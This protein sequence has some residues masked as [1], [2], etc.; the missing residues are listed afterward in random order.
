MAVI[1]PFRG[2][3]YNPE[4]VEDLSLV[5]A[6]PYDVISPDSQ[7]AFHA[8]HDQNVIRLI[9]GEI[10]EADNGEQN[11]YRRAGDDFRRWQ[12]EKILVRDP[13]PS[14]YLYQQVFRAPGG[15]ELT[16]R[17]LIALVRLEDFGGR[18]VFPHERTMAAPKE[19]RLRLMQS[20]HANLS[21][22][23]GIY[24][25]PLL[26]VDRLFITEEK[27]NPT[28]DLS[29]WDGIRHRVWVFHDRDLIAEVRNAFE[30]TPIFIA[31]GHHRYETAL[32][33]RDLMR[34]K[35]QG[36]HSAKN[37]RPYNYIMM[38]LVSA[39]DPGLVILPIH[40][41]LRDLP[42]G[43]LAAYLAQVS[44]QFGVERMAFPL[45][46]EAGAEAVLGR[47]QATGSGI[48]RFGLY[49]GGEGAYVLTLAD[50][51]IVE[52]EV[53]EGKP[54]AYKRLD[55]TILHALLIEGPLRRQGQAALPDDA[56]VYT[57][58]AVEAIRMVQQGRWGAAFFLNPTKIA[59]VQAVA[60]AGL[61]MPPKSTFFYPKLLT[62]LVI[63]PILLDE[64]VEA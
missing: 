29:D 40:R 41:L 49:V 3:R 22:I 37:R 35:D 36:D 7:R 48:H 38:T 2:L 64:V 32:A 4:L 30:S 24:P 62:G 20:C 6:P 13:A 59:E 57:H 47:L 55:V 9:L 56:F 39:D 27:I 16:R 43:G 31:D 15:E 18:T 21:P 1:A 54:G 45:D 17:G 33:F 42:G 58:D 63:H 19:D 46:P 51:R 23:F 8:R 50:E 5:V 11:R 60:G 26:E 34:A 44:Q 25:G 14:M 28:I 53:A 10:R 61:R 12:A 52:A